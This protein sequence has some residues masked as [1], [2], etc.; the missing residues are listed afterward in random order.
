MIY[1]GGPNNQLQASFLVDMPVLLSFA[2][3]SAWVESYHQSFSQIL[4]D[5]GAF[6]AYNTGKILDPGK[7]RTFALKYKGWADAIACID[8]IDGNYKKTIANCESMPTGIG[9]PTYHEDE[10]WEIIPDLCELARQHGGWIGIGLKPPRNG[11]SYIVEKTCSL[12]PDD[13]HVHGWALVEHENMARL[14]STDS[15]NWFR[16]SWKV[17][18][19]YP[20]LTP[21][22]C[23]EVIVKR[24][25]RRERLV[26]DE[27][28]QAVLFEGV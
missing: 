6:S 22:E 15:T 14:D 4:I 13:L 26:K 23:I 1:L 21:A 19:N 24:Y 10:P 28:E 27:E 3:W 11:K 25:Q 17:I 16:D 20:W 7:Y 2:Y 5:S 8:D 18:N 9:F 12:M